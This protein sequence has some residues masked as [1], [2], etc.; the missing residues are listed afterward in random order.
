MKILITGG[1]GY[2]AKK[3][4]NFLKSKYEV[5]SICRNDFDLNDLSSTN[6]WF[7]GK[8]F[9]VV[10]H[11]AIKGGSR[12]KEDDDLTYNYNLSLYNNLLKNKHHYNKLISFGSGAEIFSQETPYGKSK[13]DISYS[14]LDET[15]FYNI[16]IYSVFDEDELS[17]RYI[18]SNIIRYVKKQPIIIHSNKIMD[19]FYMKDLLNLVDYYINHDNLQKEI[20]CSYE[21][22]YTLLN[23]ANMIN[24]LDNYKVPIIVE[25]KST[26]N[27]YCGYNYS[28]PIATLGLE[29]GVS[30]V[31]NEIKNN[32]VQYV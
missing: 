19:F 27:F 20:N 4:Y 26:F 30:Y 1:N 14:I 2:V 29:R 18:K 12:L 16:R 7:K 23:I 10:L 25:D 13:K 22:K 15:N 17:T 6:K 21:E 31:F 24:S 28:F 8:I 11:T 9:D 5:Y 3:L 32:I